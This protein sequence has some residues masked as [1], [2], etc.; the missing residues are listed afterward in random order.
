[1]TLDNPEYI[2]L[3]L[4]LPCFVCCALVSYRTV[5]RWLFRFAGKK[6]SSFAFAAALVLLSI[7]LMALI[8]SLAE[9]KLNYLKTVFNR[10]GIDLALG[11]DVSKSML[12]EDEMIPHEGKKLFPIANRLNRARY[13]ALNILS[14]LRGERVG[15]FMFASKGVEVIPPTSD[16]GYCQYLLKH[17]NDATITIPGSDLS[18]AIMTGAVLLADA[19]VKRVKALILISDGEDISIDPA[20]MDEAARRAAAQGIKIYTIGIG[21][22]RGVLIPIRDTEGTAIIDYYMDEDGFY[23]KTRLEQDTLKM[24][25]AATGGSYFHASEEHC[26]D[27]V[28]EA[29]VK[30]ARTVEYTKVTEPA[31]FYLSPVLLGIGLL[32][33]CSGIIAS[34]W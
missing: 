31:W 14:A 9:P 2:W 23:L 18:E 34:R 28:V 19:S 8:L 13:C 33:F 6:K 15:V 17:L 16:Y 29:I 3:L 11:I 5:A 20:A 25:A 27:R 1:M 7:G 24:I 4:I 21:M 30:H 22:G 32:T 12:A 26:E 10:G